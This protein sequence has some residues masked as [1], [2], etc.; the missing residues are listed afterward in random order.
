MD[1][2]TT[3]L[4]QWAQDLRFLYSCVFP[5]SEGWGNPLSSSKSI[6]ATEG[7]GTMVGDGL[8]SDQL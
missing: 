8:S 5:A 7:F 6:S 3:A 4:L 1:N 2:G